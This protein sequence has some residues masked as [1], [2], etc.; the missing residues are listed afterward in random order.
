ML[1]KWKII[2][3]N[4][5]LLLLSLCFHKCPF[6]LK[7]YDG[8]FMETIWEWCNNLSSMALAK[9]GEPNIS[10]HFENGV[11]VVVTVQCFS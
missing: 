6:F 1:K 7:R 10:P 11:L 8:P 2:M 5:Q 4:F 9:V 3:Y